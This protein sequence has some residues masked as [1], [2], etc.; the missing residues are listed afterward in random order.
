MKSIG[1]KIITSLCVAFLLAGCQNFDELVE[2]K[3]LPTA[4]TPDLLLT[5][6]LEH[7]NDQNAWYGKQGSMSAAQFFVSTYDYYGTNNYDQAPFTRN[8]NSFEYVQVLENLERIDV[9]TKRLGYKDVNVYSAMGKFLKAYY[10]N[11]MSQ[12][13]GDVPLKMAFQATDGKTPEYD[14]QKDVYIQVL[15]WLEEANSD[16]AA[17]AVA[18]PSINNTMKGAIF[19]D[20]DIAAWRKVVN[21]FTLR[22]LISLSHKADD[23]DLKVKTKFAAILNNPVMYPVMTGISDNVQ[24]EYNQQ[25]NNYPKNPTSQ[26]RDAHRENIASAFLDVTTRLHDPRTYMVATPAPAL[27]DETASN[28]ADFAVYKG[29]PAGLGISDLGQNAQG[30]QYSFINAFRYYVDFAGSGA[31]PS[32]IIGYPEMCFNIAEGINRGWTTGDDEAWYLEGI[33]SSFEFFGLTDGKMLEIGDNLSTIKYGEVT[34]DLPAYFAQ[35][36]VIY[37]GGAAGLTQ[38]L[39]QK[40][41]A[42]WQN[43]NWEA[44]FNQRRTGVPAFD[45][46]LGTGNGSK[47]PVRWQYPVAE[48]SANTANYDKAVSRQFGAGGDT[49]NGLMWILQ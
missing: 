26:G 42:F 47:I 35:S 48:S 7:L 41:I 8:S 36:E 10:F 29:A 40:Y 2:N 18:P 21:T 14:S 4:V 17:L 5:G 39:E 31:E 33:N 49:L 13:L 1:Y 9:E 12:K 25:F 37:K 6:A 16:L 43:S 11:L 46:G 23:A 45:T 44:F 34:V 22:V 27:L 28:F 30:G 24:Y 20:N 19:L 38:I 15:K 32:I 3:N